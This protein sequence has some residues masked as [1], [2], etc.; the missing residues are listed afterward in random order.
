[1]KKI[2]EKYRAVRFRDKLIAFVL[3]SA[4]WAAVGVV[5][6][7][8]GDV[9]SSF[10]VS[11][12]V[13]FVFEALTQKA[14]QMGVFFV[15]AVHLLLSLV[16]SFAYASFNT[17]DYGYAGLPVAFS[18]LMINTALF[19]ALAVR[20]SIGRLWLTLTLV[21]IGLD[22]GGLFLMEG[23][24]SG[25]LFFI[26]LAGLI[27]LVPRCIL[28]RKFFSRKK[29]VEVHVNVKS[30]KRAMDYLNDLLKTEARDDVVV[31]N[32]EESRI[33][34]IS[35]EDSRNVW[36]F[37]PVHARSAMEI[38]DGKVMINGKD[39]STIMGLLHEEASKE[40]RVTKKR[41]KTMHVAVVMTNAK[42]QQEIALHVSP[43]G[44]QRNKKLVS[45][46]SPMSV[47]RRVNAN[48]K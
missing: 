31:R 10:A 40:H 22:F 36:Y 11:M 7:V 33:G 46:L 17:A 28:W 44:Y 19:S 12:A 1:M 16:V 39:Y 43:K 47:L 15:V 5:S 41:R 2:L 24:G 23:F 38:T 18:Y 27:A 32:V 6:G 4:L 45:V 34:M 20:Y 8:V 30:T 26:P 29:E 21:Y 42:D 3:L 37:H 13:L 35:Y 14:R 9:F 48:S 25:S